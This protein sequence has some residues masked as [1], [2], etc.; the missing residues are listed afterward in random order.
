MREC[1][2]D[3][4][5]VVVNAFAFRGDKQVAIFRDLDI[6]LW[7]MAE[8]DALL[9]A[10]LVFFGCRVCL[11]SGMRLFR[12]TLSR[13][14]VSNEEASFCCFSPVL[15]FRSSWPLLACWVWAS[16]VDLERLGAFFPLENYQKNTKNLL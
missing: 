4:C 15:K 16:A 2:W 3:Y 12:F 5:W 9:C 10:F 13:A 1:A 7:E 14:K 6:A 8:R 11:E